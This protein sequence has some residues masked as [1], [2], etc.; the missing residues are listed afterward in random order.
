MSFSEFLDVI[1]EEAREL[2]IADQRDLES[3]N[4]FESNGV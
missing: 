1:D 4:K 2:S 3:V